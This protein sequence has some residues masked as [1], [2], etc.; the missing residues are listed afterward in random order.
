MRYIEIYKFYI[1]K[2]LR[3]FMI[4]Y[5][6]LGIYYMIFEKYYICSIIF[7]RIDI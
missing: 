3:K 2:I 7:L 6:N 5:L 1:Y 4:E